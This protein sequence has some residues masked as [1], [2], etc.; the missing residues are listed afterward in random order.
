MGESTNHIERYQLEAL[1]MLLDRFEE[2][3]DTNVT[4]WLKFEEDYPNLLFFAA[5]KSS[6]T[7]RAIVHLC[8]SGFPDAALA[9]ARQIYEQSILLL[10]FEHVRQQPDFNEYIEDFYADCKLQIAKYDKLLA[11]YNSDQDV[12]MQCQNKI[13]TICQ[14]AHHKIDGEYWWTRKGNFSNVVDFLKGSLRDVDKN[15]LGIMHL[16]YKRACK[17]VHAG[18]LGNM[19]RLGSDPGMCGVDNTAKISGH[20]QPLFF[21]ARSFY[22]ITK[23]VF[24]NL[25]IV[26]EKLINEFDQL[27]N[28]YAAIDNEGTT[29]QDK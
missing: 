25:N 27:I 19:L 5:G 20:G 23:I 18:S 24:G 14:E 10:F 21:A 11:E 29:N 4:S 17:D 22:V 3:L 2:L 13:N 12:I 1:S 16:L 15:H 8:A 28:L 6:L 26:D 7:L 9:L